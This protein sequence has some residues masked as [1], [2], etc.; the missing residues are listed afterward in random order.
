MYTFLIVKFTH[1]SNV[2]M[3]RCDVFNRVTEQSA[4]TNETRGHTSKRQV[5]IHTNAIL[6]SF[7]YTETMSKRF[8]S[9][10]TF[11]KHK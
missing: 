5:L 2:N 1:K 11:Q 7:L 9:P 8:Q 3:P 6:F 4:R 10:I